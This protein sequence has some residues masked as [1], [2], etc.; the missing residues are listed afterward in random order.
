MEEKMRKKLPIGIE[1][2][3]K[4]RADNFYYIDKT[5]MIRDLLLNWGEVNL[6]TRP[7][8]FGKSLNMSMLKNF[9]E[10]GCRSEFFDGLAIVKETEL[11]EKY[12][13]K[14]PVVSVSLKGV[15]GND[16]ETAR[17]MMC[18]VIGGEAMRFQFLAESEKL[19]DK[20]KALYD[21]MVL[22]IRNMF[23]RVL[24][25]NDN[26]YFAVLTGCLRVAKESIFTGLNNFNVLTI[27]DVG[28]EEYFG[29]TDREV[30]E[31]LEYYGLS[32]QYDTVKE[33]YD[34]Y[35]FGNM[36]VYCPW[37]VI[38]YCGRLRLNPKAQ[39]ES[40]WSNTSSNAVIRRFLE[41]ARSTTKQEIERL[42]SGES[43]VKAV[44]QELTYKEMYD[45]PDNI[46]SV[47]FTTGYLTRRGESEG[48]KLRLAIPNKEI[49]MIFEEQISEWFQE[50]ARKDGE[51]L[52]QIDERRYTEL[53]R[54][55]GMEKILKYGIACYKKRCRVMMEEEYDSDPV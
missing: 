51:A 3:E 53:L 45:S 41:S 2:F 50:T 7:R 44:R 28:F 26:L 48:N 55:D 31:M 52:K 46:W 8:R 27:T 15:N 35:R 23:E 29:F 11:C 39:P 34:G 37:D 10:I 9:F 5:G 22:L 19:T 24:K 4:I 16:Y 54:D 40:Y 12:M 20:E 33:W 14:F 6:F 36:D 13:G 38:C 47:L 21:Q 32:G 18:T 1:S 30:R 17:S 43:I 25:T 42:I 49:R